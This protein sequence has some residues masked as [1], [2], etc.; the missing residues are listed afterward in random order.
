MLASFSESASLIRPNGI[1]YV[2]GD[3]SSVSSMWAVRI[4]CA[5]GWAEAV[6][7]GAVAENDER[8]IDGEDGAGVLLDICSKIALMWRMRRVLSWVHR[9]HNVSFAL[10]AFPPLAWPAFSCSP[11]VAHIFAWTSDKQEDAV[12]GEVHILQSVRVR[13]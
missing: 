3:D 8:L 1:E 5:D 9:T 6:A 7:A 11:T 2:G 13:W 4:C 10:G 12:H